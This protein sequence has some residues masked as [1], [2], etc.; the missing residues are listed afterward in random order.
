M[1]LADEVPAEWAAAI[2]PFLQ[3]ADEFQPRVPAVAYFLRTHAAF[4]AM[5]LRRKDSCGTEFVMKLLNAL[6]SEK[7]RLQQEL[8]GVDGR[9]ILTR[10]ALMLFAKADDEE[11]SEGVTA[12][13]NLMRL[14]F[15]SSILFEATAQFTEDGTLDPIALE[16]RDYARYI[17]VRLK[18]ALDSGV[19]YES[20]NKRE[21]AAPTNP[22]AGYDAALENRGEGFTE[23]SQSASFSYPQQA[24]PQTPNSAYECGR[25]AAGCVSPLSYEPPKAFMDSS[26]GGGGAAPPSCFNQQ[27]TPQQQPAWPSPPSAAQQSMAAF[28]SGASHVHSSGDGENTAPKG[29]S[30]DAIIEAQNQAKQAVSALQFYDYEVARKMLRTALDLLGDK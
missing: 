20:P 22:M 8:N 11:R 28:Q 10:Y 6:E 12:N 7:Q 15:T 3:R 17:A 13:V 27:S 24:V 18:K 29:P 19:P 30:L 4:L 14:F 9:T 5:K 23:G 16:K 21:S 25:P 26:G 2:R 1:S